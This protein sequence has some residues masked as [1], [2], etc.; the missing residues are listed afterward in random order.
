MDNVTV[1]LGADGGGARRGDEAV[2]IG[3]RAASGSRRGGRA[4][5]GHD[6]LRG[7]LRH[8]RARAAGLPPRRDAGGVIDAR[9][10]DARSPASAAWLV[11]GA[12]ATALL[13]RATADLDLAVDGDV[14]T[15]AARARRRGRRRVV[16]ALRRSSAR[17]AC[18]AARPRLAGR[19]RARC[20]GGSL[21]ADLAARDF[22]VN[23][24]AEPLAGGELDRPARRRAPTSP[25]GGCGWSRPRPFADD[26]L[27]ALRVARLAAEL[28]LEVEP[29]TAARGRARAR[30]GLRRVAPERVFA[31]L[32]RVVGARR[33]AARPAR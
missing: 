1:D 3:A 20:S 28:G 16:R 5:A 24:M 13:G 10:R 2:L 17:G 27:R 11:G 8:L 23:A 25:R 33:A 7:D 29:A 15:A 22:T 30:R 9:C 4:A 31:E 12:S 6:Q 32:K 21:E 19:P 14:R 18:V 26:P